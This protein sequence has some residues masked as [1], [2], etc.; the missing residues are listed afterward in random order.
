V[1]DD[2]K[3]ALR[4]VFDATP[5]LAASLRLTDKDVAAQIYIA[6]GQAKSW[7]PLFAGAPGTAAQNLLDADASAA[8]RLAVDGPALLEKLLSLDPALKNAL[9]Q[10]SA[11]LEKRLGLHLERDL[12]RNLAGKATLSFAGFDK[13]LITVALDR[14]RRGET[15]SRMHFVFAAELRDKAAL[16]K[17]LA[18]AKALLDSRG[19]AARLALVEK[20]HPAAKFYELTFKRRPVLQAAVVGSTLLLTLGTGRMEKTLDLAA[21]KGKTLEAA[22]ASELRRALAVE[23]PVALGL[24]FA[25]L[26]ASL[27]ALDFGPPGGRGAALRAFVNDRLAPLFQAFGELGAQARFDGAGVR[28]DALLR[29][30]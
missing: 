5:G 24:A 7:A 29:G 3:R 30:K 14:A 22:T 11:D 18:S 9:A 12:L 4:R 27:R 1:S 10:F 2:E 6:L 25:P 19:A 8:L 20:A 17:M 21:G 28:I 13:D 15:L 23:A 16:E 26:L